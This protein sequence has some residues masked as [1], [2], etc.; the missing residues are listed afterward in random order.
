M[1]DAAVQRKTGSALVSPPHMCERSQRW[2]PFAGVRRSQSA[3]EFNEA[4]P[5][6][7]HEITVDGVISDLMSTVRRWQVWALMAHQDI[8]M[9]YKRSL[10]GPFWISI[11]MAAFVVGIGLLYSQ[12]LRQPLEGYLVYLGCGMLAWNL[13]SGLVL[14]G[15]GAVIENESN[16]RSV[17]LPIP[18]LVARSV[19]RNLIIFLHNAVVIVGLMILFGHVWTWSALWSLV[20]LAATLLMGFFL[21]L[22]LAPLC[23]RFRD[24]MQVLA[25]FMQLF[26]F[27]TPILW[28]A[29]STG[30]MLVIDANPFHHFIEAIR[31]PLLGTPVSSLTV[32]AIAGCLVIGA[33]LAVASLAVSRKQVY[34]WI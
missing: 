13:L 28:T 33:V 23:T 34:V 21:A 25:N 6:E 17:P 16:L 2:N 27:L 9:R 32:V 4:R 26:F 18:V 11:S 29:N 24:I 12:I 14:D 10:I 22:I 7:I 15:A 30:R 8:Q 20:G 19:Y 5:Y 1:G 31:A 3:I